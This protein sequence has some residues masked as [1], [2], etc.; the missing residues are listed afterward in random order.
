MTTFAFSLANTFSLNSLLFFKNHAKYRSGKD[1]ALSKHVASSSD[2]NRSHVPKK[3]HDQKT[4]TT[5]KIEME[6]KG[7][8]SLSQR[9]GAASC[10]SIRTGDS[11]KMPLSKLQEEGDRK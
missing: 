10:I 1:R 3:S 11:G 5:K 6:N 7:E 8:L 9:Y 4:K 2:S